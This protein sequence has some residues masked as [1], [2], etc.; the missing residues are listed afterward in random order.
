MQANDFKSLRRIEVCDLNS[1]PKSTGLLTSVRA[2]ATVA[3]LA[4]NSNAQYVTA[5]PGAF[6]T[7][8]RNTIPTQR[9]NNVDLAVLKRFSLTER[10]KFEFGAQA[11]NIFNHPQFVTGSIND[12]RS[13]A[14]TGSS[15][16]NYLKPSSGTF[17]NARAT[18]PSQARA[19]QLSAKLVF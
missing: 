16:L 18:F 17:N 5:G 15:V 7:A 2:G 4:K 13:I 9:I 12:V 14:Q 3:Y 11:F 10:T 8:G 19:I 1:C 6:T